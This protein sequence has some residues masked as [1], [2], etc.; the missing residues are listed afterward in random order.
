MLALGSSSRLAMGAAPRGLTL[1]T[2][3]RVKG[4]DDD[5]VKLESA[6]GLCTS[7]TTL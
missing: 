3:E 6:R 4:A 1:Y 5:E 7:A 2:L